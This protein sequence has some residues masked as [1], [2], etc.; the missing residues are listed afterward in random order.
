MGPI[1]YS[2]CHKPIIGPLMW[3]LSLCA[4]PPP[5]PPVDISLEKPGLALT[6]KFEVPVDRTYPL[7]LEFDFPTAQDRVNDKIVGTGYDEHCKDETKHDAIIDK[8]PEIYGKVI[9]IRVVIKEV[10]GSVVVLDKTFRSSCSFSVGI[11]DK[12]REVGYLKLARGQ[13]LIEIINI[14]GQPE[15]KGIQ[16][17]IM[18]AGGLGK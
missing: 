7:I 15:L 11:T 13:Y 17:R 3:I 1:T 6:T 12:D 18:L 2:L 4:F 10:F 9:P 14:S 5:I 16:T 8:N